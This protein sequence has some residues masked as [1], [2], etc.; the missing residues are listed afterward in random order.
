ML[1]DTHCHLD[2][3]SFEED[4]QRVV[5]RAI[6]AG[7]GRILNPGINLESSRAAINLAEKYPQVFA[8]VGVHP[9]EALSWNGN[10]IAELKEMSTHPK[11]RAIGEIGLDHYRD[12]APRDLQKRI[13]GE[14]LTLAAERKLPVIIHSRQSMDDVIEI[15]EDWQRDLLITNPDLASSPGVLHS[16]SGDEEDLQDAQAINFYIGITGPVT[17]HNAGSLRDLVIKSPLERILIETDSPFLSPHPKRG[18]RNEPAN[19]RLV[20]EKIAELHQESY[21]KIIEITS[22]NASR[23]FKW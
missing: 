3:D 12:R 17:F 22:T 20:A 8:A 11:V 7:V 23:L 1:V 19:V 9:N 4:R 2:F 13:F 15:I 21:N 14:Q 5:E 6:E 18:K 10:T 16:F